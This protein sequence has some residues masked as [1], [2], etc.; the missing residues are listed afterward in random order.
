MSNLSLTITNELFK[1][2][3]LLQDTYVS[4]RKKEHD[5]EA[6]RLAHDEEVKSL[7]LEIDSLKTQILLMQ[8]LVQGT[9]H[10]TA[11]EPKAETE[12]YTV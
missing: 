1:T 11:P 3:M 7:N 10:K 12:E 9:L 5:M 6:L 4:A 8:M 2:S